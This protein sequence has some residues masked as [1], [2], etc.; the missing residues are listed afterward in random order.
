MAKLLIVDDNAAVCSAL[1]L[2]FAVH[3]LET[4]VARSPEEALAV[5]GREA[6]GVV[7][8][9]MNFQTDTTSGAEGEQLMRAIRAIDP[10]MPVLLMTAYTSLETAVKLV[11][12]G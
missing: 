6:V 2:L 12:E 8:Q 7:L 3:D 10:E 4:V 5:I 11:K 9:D 1:E